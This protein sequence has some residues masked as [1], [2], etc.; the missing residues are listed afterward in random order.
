MSKIILFPLIFGEEYSQ[1]SAG[2]DSDKITLKLKRAVVCQVMMQVRFRNEL[3]Q[4]VDVIYRFK[5]LFL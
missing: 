1:I 4:T 2:S 5:V 3:H